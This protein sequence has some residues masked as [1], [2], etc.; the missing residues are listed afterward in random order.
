MHEEP[1]APNFGSE[2]AHE[3]QLRIIFGLPGERPSKER[4]MM[5]F[6]LGR[7]YSSREELE[8]DLPRLYRVLPGDMLSRYQQSFYK[9]EYGVPCLPAEKV[10]VQTLPAL[11]LLYLLAVAGFAIVAFR[12]GATLSR[13]QLWIAMLV[14]QA[15]VICLSG[16]LRSRYRLSFEP[17]FLLGFF[18]LL[19][20]VG[21]LLRKKW[22]RSRSSNE[23]HRA[24][25]SGP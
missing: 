11:P 4:K 9:W 15:L 10:G 23:A 1:S 3:K 7:E 14:F 17:W 13:K 16:S 24:V 22:T 20:F 5:K 2:W 6:Y 19:D 18:C 21:T 12:E 8:Q 25:T